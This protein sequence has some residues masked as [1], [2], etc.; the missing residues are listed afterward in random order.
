LDVS[1]L[2]CLNLLSKISLLSYKLLR[3]FWILIIGVFMNP[4]PNTAAHARF[5]QAWEEIQALQV[6]STGR[7]EAFRASYGMLGDRGAT[8][9]QLQSPETSW[10]NW[11]ARLI[12]GGEG[13]SIDAVK[14]SFRDLRG[15]VLADVADMQALETIQQGKRDFIVLLEE[16]L[17]SDRAFLRGSPGL[18]EHAIDRAI[19]NPKQQLVALF[20]A[21]N[22]VI[23]ESKQER[24]RFVLDDALIIKAQLEAEKLG[25]EEAVLAL[26]A[27]REILKDIPGDE[28]NLASARRNLELLADTI[29]QKETQRLKMI[30]GIDATRVLIGAASVAALGLS[31]YF[32]VRS[33]RD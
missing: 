33:F 20:H 13:L 25:L 4:F 10:A 22:R 17:S 24:V 11:L 30:A 5:Y 27:Y 12:M 31:G 16:T 26:E 1:K 8:I 29:H 28:D 23:Q 15:R 21:T 9:R 7:K 2:F 32:L 14:R 3:A 6:A 18:D 19:F